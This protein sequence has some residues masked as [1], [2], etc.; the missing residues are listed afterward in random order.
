VHRRTLE[1]ARIVVRWT[2]KG[3]FSS[4]HLNTAVKNAHT[5]AVE[6]PIVETLMQMI[7]VQK[8][9]LPTLN[10]VAADASY[11]APLAA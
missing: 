11:G 6:A 1:Y 3:N 10:L 7:Y 2:T 8:Y 4:E 5:T 9:A